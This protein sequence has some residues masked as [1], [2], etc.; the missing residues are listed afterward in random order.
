MS[1]VNRLKSL[2]RWAAPAPAVDF[3]AVPFWKPALGLDAQVQTTGASVEA[4]LQSRRSQ[5]LL[6]GDLPAAMLEHLRERWPARVA[7]TLAAAERICAHEFDLLGSGPVV[8]ADPK[9]RRSKTYTPIDWNIDPIAGLKFPVKFPH[10]AYNPSLRPGM[11]DIKWPWEIGRCQH[12]V[13]LGQAYRLSGDERFAREIINQ[14]DDYLE[15]NPVG[16][17]LQFVCTMDVA[18]RAF[19]WAMAFEMI[20]ASAQFTPAAMDRAYRAL[21]DLGQFI[22]EN[23]ENT[24]EVTSN[25]FL[26]NIVGLYAVGIAF[27]DLEVGQRWVGRSRDWLEQEMR[28]Q[29]L[30][31]GVDYESSIPYHRLVAE[32]FMGAAR[33]AELDGAPLSAF[34]RDRLRLMIEAHVALLRPDGLMPQVG[35]ADDGRLHILTD[36]GTW[37]PQEGR[38]LAGPAAAMFAEPLWFES[39]G[40][41]GLWEAAW[42]GFDIGAQD[43]TGRLAPVAR[44]LPEAGLAVSR[45]RDS[46]L[47]VTNGRVGTSG[48]GNHK[49]NDLLSFE[50]HAAGVPLVV[51]PGSYLY[52][53][54]PEM[55][56]L[57]R[58][59]RS[60]NTLLIDGVEQN[61]LRL[62]YLF[63]MFETSSVE[64]VVFE[65][66]ADETVYRGRHTGYHRLTAPATHD[67]EFRLSKGTGALTILDRVSGSGSH[68]L[69]WHFHIAPGVA[70]AAA[71]G[72]GFT[73]AAAGRQWH[74]SAPGRV[75]ASV[76]DAWYSP[77]FGVRVPCR[78][79]DFVITDDV[80]TAP[81][82]GFAIE[83]QRHD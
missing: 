52:T 24:Y 30:A 6:Y 71:I 39:G 54:N 51:D 2:L 22:E 72:G 49:H 79:I 80:S 10:K 9:R 82:Y 74:L 65:D 5:R 20:R 41:H 53:S 67:R 15:A 45:D 55:R 46:Y 34:Y 23:L 32:L 70:V 47:L 8:I 43:S 31:D 44:L 50:F 81:E 59:T 37:Q 25:H 28:V 57:F 62:D 60:H 29:V 56:N 16:T 17:G 63:R 78:A 18:I 68:H 21:F 27:R 38:H 14:L 76:S 35:D 33:L 7:S 4:W 3:S 26:S 13:A 64:H 66:T 75:T 48:F 12:W 19:N 83:P 40:E 58:S 69:A 61:D 73:L 36:Y 42:W 11:A 1:L 77:S